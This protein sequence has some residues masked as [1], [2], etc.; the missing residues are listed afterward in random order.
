MT[1]GSAGSFSRAEDK[2]VVRDFS[3][4]FTSHENARLPVCPSGLQPAHY[5][6]AYAEAFRL[7][8]NVAQIV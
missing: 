4:T 2:F 8:F 1:A 3:L 6:E 7:V 5:L